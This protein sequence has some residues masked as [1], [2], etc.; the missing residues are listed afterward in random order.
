M[1][2]TK[3]SAVDQLQQQASVKTN[4]AVTEGQHDVE[5]LKSAGA[6]YVGQAKEIIDKAISTAQACI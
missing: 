6:G 2:G 4:A 5:A 1:T 3:P